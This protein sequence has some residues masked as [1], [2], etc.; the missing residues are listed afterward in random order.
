METINTTKS[1]YDTISTLN[2][3]INNSCCC[4]NEY[5]PAWNFSSRISDLTKE[6]SNERKDKNMNKKDIGIQKVKNVELSIYGPAFRTYDNT[7]ISYNKDTD[8]WIDVTGLTVDNFP[9]YSI[10]CKMEDLKEGDYILNNGMWVRVV[11][12]DFTDILVEKPFEKE[13]VLLKPVKNFFGFDF[14]TK[15]FYFD[16][17]FSSLN[18]DNNLLPFL[19]KDE[20]DILSLLFMSNN[21]NMDLNL[22][23]PLMMYLL[24]KDKDDDNLLP[25][26]LMM[27]QKKE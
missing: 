11:D 2:Y 27:N 21:S 13:T 16:V 9:F 20:V 4:N 1:N 25:L 18:I 3:D 7:L 22:D 15:L 12:N 10:P 24:L 6:N 17:D 5:V 8:E 19:L 23:N 14:Y 26:L